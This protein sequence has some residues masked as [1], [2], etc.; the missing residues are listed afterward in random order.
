[1]AKRKPKL[2][3][4]AQATAAAPASPPTLPPA[5]PAELLIRFA[6]STGLGP[7]QFLITIPGGR[8]SILPA[9]PDSFHALVAILERLGRSPTDSQQQALAKAQQSTLFPI[10][11]T[12]EFIPPQQSAWRS[13]PWW[14]KRPGSEL[15]QPTCSV[16]VVAHHTN[17][18]VLCTAPDGKNYLLPQRFLA[19]P[20]STFLPARP[21]AGAAKPTVRNLG[22]ALSLADLG[23]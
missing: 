2:Q 11:S 13:T 19:H 21:K 18:S 1:M 3:T 20:G 4:P 14:P 9:D 10:G 16:S 5:G 22:A 15:G 8:E 6:P 7:R 12:A 23:L 17:G